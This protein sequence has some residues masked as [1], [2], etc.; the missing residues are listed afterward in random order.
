MDIAE[1]GVVYFSLGSTLKGS[2]IKDELKTTILDTLA[3]LPYVVIWKFEEEDLPG[4]PDNVKI[5]KWVPQQ[6]L[7]RKYR[8]KVLNKIVVRRNFLICRTLAIFL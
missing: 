6:D 2:L 4:K 1:N 7:L 5:M 3:D 8:R